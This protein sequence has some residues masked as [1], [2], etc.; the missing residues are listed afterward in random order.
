MVT[1]RDVVPV[2]KV[3]VLRIGP[4]NSY[5]CITRANVQEVQACHQFLPCNMHPPQK[6]IN[7]PKFLVMHYLVEALPRQ[8]KYSFGMS[9][10]LFD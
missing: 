2:M 9:V 8:T 1:H 10:E 5:L 4:H 7:D 3:T 6:I